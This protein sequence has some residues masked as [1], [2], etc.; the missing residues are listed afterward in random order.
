MNARTVLYLI[1]LGV[2]AALGLLV[3][4]AYYKPV[5]T[6]GAGLPAVTDQN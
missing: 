1:V 3:Y 2:C 4:N 6:T 5:S